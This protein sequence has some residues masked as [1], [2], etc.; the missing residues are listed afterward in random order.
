MKQIAALAVVGA[1]VAA[2]LYSSAFDTASWTLVLAGVAGAGLL[3]GGPKP[4]IG[5]DS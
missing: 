1:G 5:M 3:G 4:P 2:F